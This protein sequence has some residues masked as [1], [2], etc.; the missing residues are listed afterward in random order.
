VPAEFYF[1]E[2]IL[3]IFPSLVEDNPLNH[4]I[5]GMFSNART[6]L[7]L[8]PENATWYGNLSD[9]LSPKFIANEGVPAFLFGLGI[10]GIY[11][12]VLYKLFRAA[13]WRLLIVWSVVIGGLLLIA[14]K[15]GVPGEQR[16]VLLKEPL[17][18]ILA[19]MFIS[20]LSIRLK[21]KGLRNMKYWVSSLLIL[22][23]VNHLY[24]HTPTTVLPSANGFDMIS[25]E[26]RLGRF[27][28]PEQVRI[29]DYLVSQRDQSFRFFTE[30]TFVVWPNT[31]YDGF[32]KSTP[33]KMSD[34]YQV[35]DYF[36]SM[37]AQDCPKEFRRINID[38]GTFV[39][40]IKEKYSH[41]VDEAV[42]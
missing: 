24:K 27:F 22:V 18:A 10:L 8:L 25:Y 17:V 42:D 37:L 2:I 38:V 41:R 4:S 21:P 30:S 12:A 26:A 23:T 40:C 35:G 3:D 36:Y 34:I 11:V 28:N 16:Y 14:I 9:K 29:A 15:F 33:T 39:F 20:W 6:Q 32:T 7:K 1:H 5:G 13:Q 31:I 19:G